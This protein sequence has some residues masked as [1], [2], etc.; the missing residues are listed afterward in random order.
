MKNNTTWLKI[1]IKVHRL[2][3]RVSIESAIKYVMEKTEL[4]QAN[5]T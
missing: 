1:F 4:E 3:Y 2:V 5:G